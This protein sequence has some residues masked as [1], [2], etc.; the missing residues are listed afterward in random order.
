MFKTFRFKIVLWYSVIVLTTL[1]LFR[2]ASIA[3]IGHSLESELDTSLNVEAGW[4]LSVLDSARA[5]LIPPERTWSDITYR[6]RVNPRKEFIDIYDANGDSLYRSINLTGHSLRLL[7]VYTPGDPVTLQIPDGQAI[8][9]LES[10]DARHDIFVAYP[11]AEIAAAQEE[12]LESFFLLV[13]A[14]LLLVAGGGFFLL[15]R[16]MRP[17][18]DLN[19][20]AE[21]LLALP[22][23]QEAPPMPVRSQDEVGKLVEAVNTIVQRMRQS[24]RQ[25]LSFSSLASHELRTPLAVLRTQ[26]ENVLSSKASREALSS[27]ATSV[28]DEILRLHHV[29]DDLLTVSTMQAGTIKLRREQIALRT[30]LEEFR[31]EAQ[32]LAAKQDVTV[33]LAP[34]EEVSIQ[35]DR[36][37]IRQMLFNLFD[38]ALKHTPP[39]GRIRLSSEAGDGEVVLRFSDTGCGIQPS[40]LVRIFDFFYKGSIQGEKGG[41]AGLG[42]ALVRWIVEMHN[43]IISVESEVGKGTTFIVRLPV[44]EPASSLY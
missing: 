24:I 11:T 32:L 41:G 30:Y 10:R 7:S 16:L 9:V 2:L 33:E 14:A 42:L 15:S 20:Y 35:A 6:S 13:P 12:V 23:D 17:I 39:G 31:T 19:L 29:V 44:A 8:R 5:Q 27:T 38:N 4:I 43:G 25:S 26:L 21:R 37:R 18:R 1:L 22:L 28:Y 36:D 3:V 40:D 34:G